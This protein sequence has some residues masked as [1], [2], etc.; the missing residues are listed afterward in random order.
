MFERT[1]LLLLAITL[2]ASCAKTSQEGISPVTT[3]EQA[4]VIGISSDKATLIANEAALKSYP[5]LSGFKA[6]VCEQQILWRIIYDGGGP[7]F[8]I[9]KISGKIILTQTI[10]QGID[11]VEPEST[12]IR[13]SG[14]HAVDIVKEDL[15][16]SVPSKD[17]D[18]Y[19]LHSC[20]LDRAWRVIV[21]PQLTVEPDKHY[22]AIPNASTRNYVIDKTTG[23][24]LFK[25]R[26]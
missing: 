14:A 24:I 6:V 26:T 17:M 23:E 10:P 20:E 4:T 12:T 22:P 2:M 7:E 1:F 11:H 13:I 3:K 19:V 15:K 8:L 18:S 9:D 25:Q 16:R 5:S 21:E